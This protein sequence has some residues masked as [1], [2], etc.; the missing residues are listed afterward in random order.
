[1][2][3]YEIDKELWGGAARFN[4]LLDE[5]RDR[6][7]EF[8]TQHYISDDIIDRFKE[9]G[10]YRAFVPKEFGGDERTPIEFMLAIEA[11][12]EADGSA[13]WVASFGMC[14]S[15]LGALPMEQ[16][17]EW[18]QNPDR[19]FA[20]AM[21]PL[22]PAQVVDG[23]YRVNGTWKYASGS[24]GADM[25]GVGIM[26]DAPNE[27]PRMAVFPADQVE[28]DTNSWQTHGMAGTGSFDIVVKD[29]VVAAEWTFVRGSK[30]NPSGPH[31]R[32]P[33]LAIASQ[34]L[35]VTSLGVA[36]A[37]LDLV[38]EAA[39]KSATGAPNIGDREYVQME[40][41]KAEA[42][43]CASRLFFYESIQNAWDLLVAGE[44]LDPHT[45]SMLRLSCTHV[46][47]ECA[48]ATQ[49]AYAAFG[50]AATFNDSDMGRR[51]RDV[52]MATQHAFMGEITY[53]YAG[54]MLFGR[55]PAPG[56]P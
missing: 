37:A 55:D 51:W 17:H 53:Q 23:G 27:Y 47:R 7:E 50:M 15:Y 19:V 54:A 20:G 43:F 34:V 14:E 31:F 1:M 12:A 13:G 25:I 16:V 3:R 46:T 5:I 42:R 41:A 45:H 52:H 40:M 30:L 8:E 24:M 26:P 48:A 38:F 18:W 39:V 33:T 9:I 11:I 56:Y 2:G 32:Y 36:R 35:A 6:T 4:E 22:Q 21:Y 49:A 29:K 10:I 28:I 44:P